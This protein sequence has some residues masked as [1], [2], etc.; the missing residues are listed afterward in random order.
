MVQLYNVILLY[1]LEHI[2]TK[3]PLAPCVDYLNNPLLGNKLTGMNATKAQTNGNAERETNN[4]QVIH[5]YLR[6]Q[7][8]NEI[9]EIMKFSI[10]ST[11]PKSYKRNKEATEKE[12]YSGIFPIS[13]YLSFFEDGG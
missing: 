3:E 1:N 6:H 13:R 8:L 2:D 7:N 4:W 5:S 11:L 12:D 10:G 9:M